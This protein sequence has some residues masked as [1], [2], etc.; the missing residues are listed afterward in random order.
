MWVSA[1]NGDL[2]NLDNMESVQTVGLSVNAQLSAD[3][4]ITLV[5]AASREEASAQIEKIAKAL[6]AGAK[7]LDIRTP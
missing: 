2:V 6:A 3:R 4:W 7:Y 5:Q 1:T